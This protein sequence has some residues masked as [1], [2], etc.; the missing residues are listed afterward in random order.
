MVQSEPA[1]NT[2]SQPAEFN[3]ASSIES[4]SSSL[5][6]STSAN[7]DTIVYP[8]Y[9]TSIYYE[10]GSIVTDI[11]TAYVT[12]CTRC[13][14]E[15]SKAFFVVPTGSFSSN[16]TP[17]NS[18]SVSFQS[19]TATSLK[20][21]AVTSAP[22]VS[23]GSESVVVPQYITSIY[24]ESG[25]IVTDIQTA[26]VTICTRC[27]ENKTKPVVIASNPVSS[28]V[29]VDST[30]PA[31]PSVVK[32]T[33][34]PSAVVVASS[35]SAVPTFEKSID[36]SKSTVSESTPTTID[37]KFSSSK[38]VASSNPASNSK[39]V[40][41]ESVI[42]SQ[43][44]SKSVELTTSYLV[45]TSTQ[46]VPQ[47]TSTETFLTVIT[48]SVP[49]KTTHEVVT[50]TVT[51]CPPETTVV[52]VTSQIV[53]TKEF[54]SEDY[55]PS[56]TGSNSFT[57]PI[58]PSAGKVSSESKP[59]VGTPTMLKPEAVTSSIAVSS[60]APSNTV[61]S[62]SQ[63]VIPSPAREV[64]SESK[65]AVGTSTM[66]KPE[67]ITSSSITSSPAASNPVASS[68]QPIVPPV[69][70]VSSESKPAV[71]T[72]TMLKPEAVTSN[73]VSSPAPTTIGESTIVPVVSTIFESGSIVVDIK[74]DYVTFC[75]KCTKSQSSVP[76][77][78]DKQ[79]ISSV[80]SL[81]V[82][83][84]AV[85]S[86]S[87]S[88]SVVSTPAAPTSVMPVPTTVG[89]STVI[90]VMSTVYESGSIVVDVK[91]NFITVCTECTKSSNPVSTASSTH[92]KKVPVEST[93]V[94]K[95]PES[96]N[97]VESQP[98]SETV[99]LVQSQPTPDNSKSVQS[100][101]SSETFKS[102]E[103]QPSSE[104]L[105]PVQ[106][107]FVETTPSSGPIESSSHFYFTSIA[108]SVSNSPIASTGVI[109]IPTPSSPIAQTNGASSIR[110]SMVGVAIAGLI[111]VLIM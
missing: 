32:A 30:L 55:K 98:A 82:S 67:G 81:P 41:S 57:Q 76:V 27:T 24:Y 31:P 18:G 86:I 9:S 21:V 28:S 94:E 23:I 111:G 65:P 99:K 49:G 79:A 75:P 11:K 46:L 48:Q 91:T 85:S 103:S 59:A 13:E 19:A 35:S 104:T 39:P 107:K 92:E 71:G 22:S 106:S 72:S 93:P 78:T 109:H 5:A 77:P 100:Q 45:Q 50:L 73:V 102:I 51:Y 108:S 2:F 8:Q 17:F 58:V 68:S 69:V 101:P 56:N 20:P 34:E 52:P 33:S 96:S 40:V 29:A 43:S 95:I 54:H 63:P 37:A 42:T 1:K 6:P 87:T 97:P 7:S 12:V 105:K 15:K 74:T 53:K 80:T 26:Y 25:S 44:A 47:T 3:T 62:S 64:S 70:E 10:S 88:E 61:A 60:S 16:D 4:V 38:P 83:S 84:L 66:L 110:S 14:E 89:E 90:P 36:V